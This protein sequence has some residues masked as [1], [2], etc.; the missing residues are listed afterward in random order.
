MAVVFDKP[1]LLQRIAP[2]FQG[3]DVPLVFAILLL[4]CAGLMT[5][6]SVGFDH[7]SRFTNPGR[8]MNVAAGGVFSGVPG[9]AAAPDGAGSPDVRGRGGLAAGG[10]PVWHTEK[11]GPALAQ[12]GRGD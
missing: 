9:V 11:G 5:M 12:C 1:T 7:G 3:F 8:H 2:I 4:A 10:V 6:Y